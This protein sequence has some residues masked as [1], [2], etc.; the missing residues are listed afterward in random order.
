MVL[1]DLSRNIDSRGST[2]NRSYPPPLLGWRV[3]IAILRS[4]SRGPDCRSFFFSHALVLTV[5]STAELL[6]GCSRGQFS[7]HWSATPTFFAWSFP[8]MAQIVVS[9][10]LRVI[11]SS[12]H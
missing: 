3:V 4:R 1:S 7:R 12:R 10:I 11:G 9:L 6:V 5:G 2:T 8:Q